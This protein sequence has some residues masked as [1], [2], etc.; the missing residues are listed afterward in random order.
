MDVYE[1][2]AAV[3]QPEIPGSDDSLSSETTSEASGEGYTSLGNR[4]S[5][6]FSG[7]VHS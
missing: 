1:S 3:S 6:G 2:V 5:R 7:L 4:E